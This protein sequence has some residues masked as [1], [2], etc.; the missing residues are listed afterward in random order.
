LS[1]PAVQVSDADELY[2]RIYRD[3]IGSDRCILPVAFKVHGKPDNEI[4]V[5]LAR[6]TTPERTL[7]MA[8]NGGAD[9]GLG[10]MVAGGPRSLGFD[11]VH[12]PLNANCAHSLIRGENSLERCARL[13]AMTC[14]I[15]H[16]A[17]KITLGG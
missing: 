11:V 2:R 14:M 9:H 10:S 8:K 17:A 1:V 13:A 6:L 3:H 15:R 16:P 4:S 7:A 12:A 5:D